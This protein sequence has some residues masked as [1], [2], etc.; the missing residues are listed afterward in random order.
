L[1]L[2]ATVLA[3]LSK[4]SA[5]VTPALLV[6][7]DVYPLRRLGGSSGW[8]GP[9]ARRV[10]CEKLP[11]VALAAVA[12]AVGGA[13]QRSAGAMRPL[14]VVGVAPRLGAAMY[15][16]GF[17]L[18]KLVL[19]LHLL[20]MYEYPIGM[21]PAHPWALAGAATAV[22][23][24]S[25]ALLLRGVCPGLP[26]AFV[27]YLATIG[28]TLGFLQ[29][30]PQIAADRY[31]HLAT[32]G[33]S[34]LAGGLLVAGSE[35]PWLRAAAI[36]PLLVLLG[37]L[38]AFQSR[39]WRDAHTMWTRVVT[40]DPSNAFAQMSMGDYARS[41][42]NLDAAAGWYRQATS[43]R[44]YAEAEVR[45][46][47]LLAARGRYDDAFAHYR[48][49]MSE[50]PR[51]AF[52]YTSYGVLL[53]DRGRLTEAVEAHRR[54]LALDP[55]LMEGHLNLGSALDDLG[56]YDEALR[57]YEAALRL[58][59]SVEVYN[60]LGV[61][62][63]KTDRALEAVPML[64]KA[65]ALRSDVATVHENLGYALRAVGDQAGAAV[66][67]EAAIRLDASL[68]RARDALTALRAAR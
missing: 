27:A 31:T 46:A 21:G 41:V 64:R 9:S 57:E 45:F 8:T 17:Y 5:M 60:N 25:S 1:T 47:A 38:A 2:A 14:D 13:A 43:E 42:G 53:A 11:F 34:V 19:P 48:M 24:G 36:C 23:V 10:W 66:A 68:S 29:S 28:P 3:Q 52:A 58:R 22:A 15:Q 16:S 61:L 59:P 30:G 62:F 39:T 44:S 6:V 67:L 20:P 4:A 49:A 32:I 55:D 50:D 35:R 7:L 63:L 37:T 56:R 65:L 12:A 51:N 26:A 40:I 33:W 18:W 54:A